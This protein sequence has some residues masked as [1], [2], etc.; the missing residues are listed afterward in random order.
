[1]TPLINPMESN[2]SENENGSRYITLNDEQV[3]VYTYREAEAMLNIA[4][5]SYLRQLVTKD[6][7]HVAKRSRIPGTE[8]PLVLL[9][10]DE[11]DAY[12]YKARGET[13]GA[14][15]YEI[16]LTAEQY[17]EFIVKFSTVRII[18]LTAKRGA[19]QK[20]HNNKKKQQK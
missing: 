18:D 14:R 10:A 2:M 19:Y 17:A 3:R 12:N 4:H 13:D 5:P 11:V 8:I 15:S 20:R 9:Y 6:K 16:R 7:I 1:M